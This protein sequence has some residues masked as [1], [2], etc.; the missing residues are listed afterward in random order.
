MIAGPANRRPKICKLSDLGYGAVE[1]SL[2]H[3][4]GLLHCCTMPRKINLGEANPLNDEQ[5]RGEQ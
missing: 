2:L 1:A 4:G 5:V 3:N